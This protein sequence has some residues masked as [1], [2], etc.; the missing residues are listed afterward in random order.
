MS[1]K[2]FYD[3]V[4]GSIILDWINGDRLSSSKKMTEMFSVIFGKEVE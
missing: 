2:G 1:A 4:F 3:E